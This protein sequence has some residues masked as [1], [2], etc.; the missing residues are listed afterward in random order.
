MDILSK[1]K[2]QR[3][4]QLHR[5]IEEWARPYLT[6]A[7]EQPGISIIGEIKRASPSKGQI[8]T[9]DFDLLK[10]AQHYANN[11]VAAFS[12]LTEEAYFKGDNAF[13]PTVAKAFPTMPILRKDFIY[14]PFQVF[15]AKSL[16][17]SAILLIVRMLTDDE[18]MFLHLLAHSLDLEVLVEVHNE[19]EL[20]RALQVPDLELLGINNRNLNTFEVSLKTTEQ[21]L[22]AIPKSQREELLIV[23]E[24]GYHSKEDIV[25]AENLGIDALLIGE[26]LMKGEIF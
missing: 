13:I 5:E 22:K 26:A 18:L 11:R 24:S 7:I 8:A 21:L 12:I 20:Q 14:T 6:Q 23:S 16:G 9:E 17:A 3:E 10:Q 25:Y 4:I 15:H 19:K 1:I 2:E